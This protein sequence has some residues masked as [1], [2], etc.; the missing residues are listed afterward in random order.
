MKTR[1]APQEAL[2]Q[3]VDALIRKRRSAAARIPTAASSD[4]PI[5]T[6]VVPNPTEQSGATAE[7]TAT[8]SG[9]ALEALTND[10]VLQLRKH[11]DTRMDELSSYVKAEIDRAVREQ[12][13]QM[14]PEL[15]HR[16]ATSVSSTVVAALNE[17]LGGS[18]AAPDILSPV[19]VLDSKK[20][21]V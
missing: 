6:D 17:A 18:P 14:M 8:A 7:A 13:A 21:E 15:R 16:I 19:E 20:S 3:Q 12:L 1:H 9:V 2:V 5:L 4:V 10:I 11:L